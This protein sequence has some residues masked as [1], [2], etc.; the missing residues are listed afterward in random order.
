MFELLYP[1]KPAPVFPHPSFR[2]PHFPFT[3]AW[4]PV[5]DEHGRLAGAI[6]IQ[7]LPKFKLL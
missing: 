2:P 4:L 3:G 1:D 7:D 5:V 6:D